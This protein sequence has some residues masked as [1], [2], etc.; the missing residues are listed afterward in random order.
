MDLQVWVGHHYPMNMTVL[1]NSKASSSEADARP[2]G[3]S[4]PVKL[5]MP[6]LPLPMASSSTTSATT[7]STTDSSTAAAAFTAFTAFTAAALSPLPML[8]LSSIVA[9]PSAAA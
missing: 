1:H 2:S 5:S 9:A 6:S 4:Q 8:Q 3:S 7:A